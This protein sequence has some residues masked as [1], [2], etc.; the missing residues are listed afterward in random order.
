MPFKFE[1]QS[2]L[3]FADTHQD[4]STIVNWMKLKSYH[5]SLLR[6]SAYQALLILPIMCASNIKRI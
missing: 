2:I 3:S 6:K 4:I 1:L 5:L